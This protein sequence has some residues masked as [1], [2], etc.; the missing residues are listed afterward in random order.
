MILDTHHGCST[1]RF[2]ISHRIFF[3]CHSYQNH[4]VL[5]YAIDY[6]VLKSFLFSRWQL[7]EFV[8]GK[9]GI[10]SVGVHFC[11]LFYVVLRYFDEFWGPRISVFISCPMIL[12][13][14]GSSGCVVSFLCE[15]YYITYIIA[16]YASPSISRRCKKHALAFLGYF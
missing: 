11:S 13:C 16:H 1:T 14:I 2:L 4:A 5:V 9:L 10:W 12:W 6:F 3:V 7:W 15:K 8:A